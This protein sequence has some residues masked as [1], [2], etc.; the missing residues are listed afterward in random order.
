MNKP[1][2]TTLDI[3]PESYGAKYYKENREWFK[4]R[5]RKRKEEFRAYYQE[6]KNKPCTDCGIQYHPICME[7]DHRDPSTKLFNVSQPQNVSSLQKLKDELAKC[8]VVCSNCHKLR[9]WGIKL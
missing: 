2:A 1:Y 4:E 6:A 7:F 5:N 9:T 3:K 8:D